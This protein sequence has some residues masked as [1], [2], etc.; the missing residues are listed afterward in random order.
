M[1]SKEELVEFSE[2]FLIPAKS[3]RV[4]GLNPYFD[5]SEERSSLAHRMRRVF[6]HLCLTTVL[7]CAILK[8]VFVWLVLEDVTRFGDLCKSLSCALFEAMALEMMFLFGFEGHKFNSL[9]QRLAE[10]FPNSHKDQEIY[11]VKENAVIVTGK[12]K[13]LAFIFVFSIFIWVVGCPVNDLLI[14]HYA[15]TTYEMELPYDIYTPWDEQESLYGLLL[16]FSI[17]LVTICSAVTTT[18]AANIFFVAVIAQISLQFKILAQNLRDLGPNDNRALAQYICHHNT[19]L[20]T[21]QEFCRLV[22][23]TVFMNHILSSFALC[24]GLFQVVTSSNKEV[25]KFLVY[26]QCVLIQTFNISAIGEA[27]KENVGTRVSYLK[28]IVNHFS[29][30]RA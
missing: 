24:L 3:F 25:F 13:K 7:V 1:E 23:R 11:S 15:N 2:Y 8:L 26:L 10:M 18:L 27:L 29:N 12:L 19:L 22:S 30:C 4:V 9:L 14:S 20:D 16:T 6:F 5:L 21:C 28:F 17:E